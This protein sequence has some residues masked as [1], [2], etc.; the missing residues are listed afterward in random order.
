MPLVLLAL[1]MIVAA[2]VMLAPPLPTMSLALAFYPSS[3]LAAAAA[4][5]L[6]YLLAVVT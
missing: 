2:L 3:A 4:D 1:L 5:G 6:D